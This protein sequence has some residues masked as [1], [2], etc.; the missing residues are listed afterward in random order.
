MDRFHCG[1][2]F[3]WWICG[4]VLYEHFSFF[5][6]QLGCDIVLTQRGF[7]AGVKKVWED[8]TND[9]QR[10][11]FSTNWFNEHLYYGSIAA[12]A[13]AGIFVLLRG[14]VLFC[15]CTSQELT[16]AACYNNHRNSTVYIFGNF[17][18]H[19][20]SA[21]SLIEFIWFCDLSKTMEEALFA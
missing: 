12:L 14:L 6:L 19:L 3:F 9:W 11:A 18:L 21:N 7:S 8:P 16:R 10:F 17:S 4:K 1:C 5:R 15:E 2:W 13:I 20:S